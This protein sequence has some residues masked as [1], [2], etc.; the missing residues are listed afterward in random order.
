MYSPI[1]KLIS[2]FFFGCCIYLLSLSVFYSFNREVQD[3]EFFQTENLTAPSNQTLNSEQLGVT[4][5]SRQS[6]SCYANA[7]CI[8]D[9]ASGR[10]LCA[11]NENE[12]K[13]MASTTKIMT[14][15]LALEYEK[16]HPNQTV[17]FSKYAASMPDVQLNAS[18][19]EEFQFRDLLYSLMLES[20]NDTAV[21]IAETISGTK[22]AFA[23]LMN[24]KAKTLGLTSTH[25]ITANG[26]DDKEHYTTAYEL[27]KLA[28]YALKNSD[29]QTI[30]QTKTHSF[31]SINQK[32]EYQVYNHDSFLSS[33]PGAIGIKTGFTN[34][35]GY[36]FCGAATRNSTTLISAVLAS[37]WPPNKSYKW[38]DTHQ[39]MDYGF[40]HYQSIKLDNRTTPFRL[41]L[42]NAVQPSFL[43][44]EPNSSFT[45]PLSTSD[46][47]SIRY[48]I[49]NSIKAPVKKGQ[50]IG[51]KDYYLN[52]QLLKSYPITA[53][54]T[55]NA[56]TFS[57]IYQKIIRRFLPFAN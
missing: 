26:L 42:Q 41:P 37:G 10:I 56:I 51:K 12:K 1:Q 3:Y 48:D 54:E 18:A 50:K 4:V 43:V 27:C 33:Y 13:P 28:S 32:K 15:I 6:P 19:G 21:A 34:N 11:K 7:Y 25:F 22:E 55:V 14:C 9:D 49:P 31:S 30:I 40:E 17:T 16:K 20:H 23:S 52:D 47:V 53:C 2:A 5:K 29:F 24:K 35:A 36:C 57:F 45:Y 46:T 44:Q 38:K 39:L 8:I